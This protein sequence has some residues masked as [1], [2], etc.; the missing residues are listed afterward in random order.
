M[1]TSN[2]L[3][4]EPAA[5]VMATEDAGEA[6]ERAHHGPAHL[7]SETTIPQQTGRATT[8]RPPGI[9]ASTATSRGPTQSEYEVE[10]ELGNLEY[11]P[12]HVGPRA[13]DDPAPTPA[14][15]PAEQAY[16]VVSALFSEQVESLCTQFDQVAE[17][18]ENQ[19][20]EQEKRRKEALSAALDAQRVAMG[21]L[22]ADVQVKLEGIR[23]GK[24]IIRDEQGRATLDEEQLR[25]PSFIRSPRTTIAAVTEYLATGDVESVSS[26]LAQEKTKKKSNSSRR[27]TVEDAPDEDSAHNQPPPTAGGRSHSDTA[28]VNP[29]L[30]H[31]PPAMT[32]VTRPQHGPDSG[33][34]LRRARLPTGAPSVPDS[35]SQHIAAGRSATVETDIDSDDEDPGLPGTA[36]SAGPAYPMGPSTA[37]FP[38]P[39]SARGHANAIVPPTAPPHAVPSGSAALPQARTTSVPQPHSAGVPTSLPVDP[40]LQGTLDRIAEHINNMVGRA[41]AGS[42]PKSGP[43]PTAPES[44]SGK[45]H[46]EAFQSWLSGLLSYLR[47]AY[48]CGPD[49]DEDRLLHTTTTLSGEAMEWWTEQVINRHFHGV[50]TWTFSDAICSLYSRFVRQG[51]SQNAALSFQRTKYSKSKGGANHFYNR[52]LKY[53]GRMIVYPDAYT[54]ARKFYNGLPAAMAESLTKIYRLTAE[55]STIDQLLIGALIIEDNDEYLE[56]RDRDTELAR[57]QP[58]VVRASSSRQT[59]SGRQPTSSAARPQSRRP[60]DHGTRPVVPPAATT[61]RHPV[62]S[63]TPSGSSAPRTDSSRRDQRPRDKTCFKCKGVGHF[64]NDSTCPLYVKPALRMMRSDEGADADVAQTAVDSTPT[65]AP[66]SSPAD[67]IDEHAAAES[68]PAEEDDDL[69]IGSQ[70]DSEVGAYDSDD[71]GFHSASSGSERMYA[72]RVSEDSDADSPPAL[73][74]LLSR[75]IATFVDDHISVVP[76]LPMLSSTTADDPDMP[77]LQDVSD[78][79]DEATPQGSDDD[80]SDDW[81]YLHPVETAEPTAAPDTT[82]A[83]QLEHLMNEYIASS[84]ADF[85]A[86]RQA[87]AAADALRAELSLLRTAIIHQCPITRIQAIVE[88]AIVRDALRSQDDQGAPRTFAS[89]PSRD[90]DLA[91]ILALAPRDTAADDGD[92]LS[93]LAT[94]TPDRGYRTAMRATSTAQQRPALASRCL[95]IHVTMN[96]LRALALID[97]GSTIN[98]VSPD[99]SRVAKLPTFELSNPIGLQL[100]CVGSR[101]RINFGTRLPVTVADHTT[102]AYFDVVN[103]DHYDVILGVPFLSQV[104]LCIDFSDRS[105]RQGLTP[106]P[107][108]GGEGDATRRTRTPARTTQSSNG[109]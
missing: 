108:L 62:P 53:A 93:A 44:Y 37:F 66:D 61:V 85:Q 83:Q 97:T 94:E 14:D 78:S 9:P 77:D 71:Y 106:V 6:R 46:H 2:V 99:F 42:P 39:V 90:Q 58:A 109:N 18:I 41:R 47:L 91:D 27:V 17:V 31:P 10:R 25:P 13:S 72:M 64:A 48:L 16:S 50:R 79:D 104:G 38:P 15:D 81:A 35:I 22:A 92:R 107:V 70:Y 74:P 55:N 11:D 5:E 20:K 3:G 65:P 12:R 49:F 7:H 84:T 96:G 19:Q 98:C 82:P 101:T 57:T 59:P 105:V 80:D 60:A 95:T 33:E 51:S 26:R 103:V 54:L 40:Y 45:N 86:L 21:K 43:R 1:S 89:V 68:S 67:D 76:G 88:H 102:D 52:M 4:M 23:K 32:P 69:Y 63:S 73:V 24:Y 87:R 8:T 28:G 29:A 56:Q 30:A 75:P 34:R 100:G 36:P